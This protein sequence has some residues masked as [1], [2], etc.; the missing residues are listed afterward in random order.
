[1]GK[2]I[3]IRITTGLELEESP[4][5]TSEKS[6]KCLKNWR[7]AHNGRKD[8]MMYMFVFMS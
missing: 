6:I 5:Q 8:G 4:E 2:V 7:E 1:M 3:A